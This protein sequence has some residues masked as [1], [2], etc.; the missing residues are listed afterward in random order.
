VSDATSFA[1]RLMRKSSQT[2]GYDVREIFVQVPLGS[3]VSQV[4][5]GAHAF[6]K[7]QLSKYQKEVRV[8]VLDPTGKEQLF[9]Q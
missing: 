4:V 1:G 5:Q 7:L 9:P 8:I 3:D 6:Q 2:R